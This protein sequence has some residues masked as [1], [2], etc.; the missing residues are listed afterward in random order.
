MNRFIQVDLPTSQYTDVVPQC[1]SEAEKIM[2]KTTLTVALLHR[3][4][5]SR[6]HQISRRAYSKFRIS[7][8][9]EVRLDTLPSDVGNRHVHTCHA[10]FSRNCT[11]THA[12]KVPFPP[13]KRGAGACLTQNNLR[14]NCLSQ[15]KERAG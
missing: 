2:L 8:R 14:T 9:P 11:F 6:F 15:Q 5:H 12:R 3:S 10:R 7:C 4:N 13:Y 1:S